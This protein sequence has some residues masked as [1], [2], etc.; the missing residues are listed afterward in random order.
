MKIWFQNRRRRAA[1]GAG[2]CNLRNDSIVSEHVADS[3]KVQILADV[4]VFNDDSLSEKTLMKKN[5]IPAA[6][7]ILEE[8]VHAKRWVH[9]LHTHTML[10]VTN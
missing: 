8:A 4:V 5:S 9:T 7:A 3:V 2:P 10:F 1:L 6:V